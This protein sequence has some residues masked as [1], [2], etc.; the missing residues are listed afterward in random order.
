MKETNTFALI[1][2]MDGTMVD[3]SEAHWIAW[4]QTLANENYDLTWETFLKTFGQRNDTILRSLLGTSLPD[5]EILRIGDAKEQAFRDVLKDRGVKFLPGAAQIIDQAKAHGWL[6]A[7]V[8]SAPR[9]NIITIMEVLNRP[10][11]FAVLV[12]AEDVHHGKPHPEGCITASQK[13]GVSPKNCIVLEDAQAGLE[14]A[15]S[16]GMAC[17]GVLSTHDHLSKADRV[18]NSLEDISLAKIETLLLQ[19]G[20]L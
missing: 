12:C 20:A 15:R 6:Q 10:D 11:T 16:A 4:Q 2:D 14:A 9:R 8:S 3:T 13:L 7:V 1:W 19:H 5:S 18:V 17:V